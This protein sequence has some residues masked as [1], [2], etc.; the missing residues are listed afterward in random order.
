MPK[1]YRSAS[2]AEARRR[3]FGST[4]C[5]KCDSPPV[6]QFNGHAYCSH[7]IHHP[8]LCATCGK[9]AQITRFSLRFCHPHCAA[10]YEGPE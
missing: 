9:K 1:R 2:K 6:A 7:P 4:H 10:I 3:L 5:W 8:D